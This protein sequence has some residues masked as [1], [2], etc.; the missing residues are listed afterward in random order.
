MLDVNLSPCFVLDRKEK[1]SGSD[2]TMDEMQLTLEPGSFRDRTSSVFYGVGGEV[3]RGLDETAL[4]NWAAFSSS[5]FGSRAMREGKIAQTSLLD[6]EA[7]PEKNG[8]AAALEHERIPF[9]S[10]PYEWC[11]GML[12][13]A[14]LLH[15]ELLS[16]A[17]EEGMII[18]DSSAYN[19][20]WRG[21]E[22]VFIDI[23]SFEK[24]KSGEPWVGYKQFCEMFLFPLML[25]AYK[26]L[27]FQP[28]LRGDI[29]GIPVEFCSRLLSLRDLFRPGCFAHVY[30]Q[31]KLQATYA[32][33]SRSMKKEL[34]S[35]GF[36]AEII[37]I[38]VRKLRRLVSRLDLKHDTTTWSDYETVSMTN[39][40]YTERDQQ[41][42]ADFVR[43]AAA[44]RRH[45]LVWDL[46]CNTGMFSK[47]AAESADCVVAMDFDHLAVEKLYRS[48]K[49]SEV[50]NVLPLVANVANASPAQGWRGT[51][52]KRFE[53]RG[54]PSL[55]LGLAL[56]HHIVI[57]A[58]VPLSEFIDWLASLGADVVL[59]FVIR[60][61]P[62]VQKLLLNKDDNYSD[63]TL[64]N[65]ERLVKE[66]FSVADE[67]EVN[68]GQRKLFHCTARS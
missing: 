50:K 43:R 67:I 58:N 63:Y 62:M 36:N 60:R 44:H 52:R 12:K 20:Q 23:P 18:K 8:W 7:F 1:V 19:I 66:R 22:P 65:F 42:K 64:D 29:D 14:A 55:V 5:E 2:S 13:D 45:P 33:T 38:N 35:S 46:G 10:Y 40:T 24:W 37:K 28:L 39:N 30:L 3:Y 56:M 47:I 61:D 15:L 34:A 21:A 32:N 27:P 54:K 53:D 16:A 48:L 4:A 11:F 26:G 57:S 68:S 41:Q 9:V 6:A 49:G 25:A 17:L 51:E 31:S 59:E